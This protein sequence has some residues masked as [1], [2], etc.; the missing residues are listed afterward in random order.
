[1]LCN[2][3]AYTY[4]RKDRK[5]KFEINESRSLSL[6]LSLGKNKRFFELAEE[7]GQGENLIRE[8]LGARSYPVIYEIIPP[9]WNLIE[10][11]SSSVLSVPAIF[12]LFAVCENDGAAAAVVRTRRRRRRRRRR[13]KMRKGAMGRWAAAAAAAA[14]EGR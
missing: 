6:S 3:C 7:S 2:V 1:M 5:M 12:L 14:G 13:R 11:L 8:K 9:W 4:T 10:Q